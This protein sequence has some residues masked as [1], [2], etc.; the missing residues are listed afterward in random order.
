MRSHVYSNTIYPFVI[1]TM[2]KMVP[3][4]ARAVSVTIVLQKFRGNTAFAMTEQLSRVLFSIWI[5]FIHCT[6][7]SLELGKV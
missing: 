4:E 5:Q 1:S 7:A 2:K 3:K 6:N